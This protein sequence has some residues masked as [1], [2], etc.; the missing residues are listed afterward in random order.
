MNDSK[1][2][3]QF[4]IPIEE[5]L[6]DAA[7]KI[8]QNSARAVIVTNGEQAVGVISEG[9]ILRALLSGSSIHSSTEVCLQPSFKYLTRKDPAE[10][11]DIVKKHGVSLVP[12]LGE[13]F[14]LQHVYPAFDLY[15]MLVMNTNHY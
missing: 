12:V 4:T 14:R 8:E 11:W 5:T 1:P 10:A 13:G 7:A 2:L 6:L 3:E 15:P 9:D